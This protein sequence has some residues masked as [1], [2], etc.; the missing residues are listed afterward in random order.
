VPKRPGVPED[1]TTFD[2][3]FQAF[4]EPIV[5]LYDV[6]P[7]VDWEKGRP[8]TSRT[9]TGRSM[10]LRPV[11]VDLLQR[12]LEA[13]NLP[14]DERGHPLPNTYV[15]LADADSTEADIRA[16][17]EKQLGSGLTEEDWQLV[18]QQLAPLTPTEPKILDLT[19]LYADLLFRAAAERYEDPDVQKLIQDLEE[20]EALKEN[21]PR[22]PWW[23][24]YNLFPTEE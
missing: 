21:V 16:E 12:A 22:D 6:G 8:Y 10:Q 23:L 7:I 13:I 19:W 17:I 11:Q 4:G 15:L 9:N 2:S 1:Q 3:L 5:H 14:E 24:R 18:E 20:L